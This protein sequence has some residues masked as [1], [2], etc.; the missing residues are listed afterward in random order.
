MTPIDCPVAFPADP[1]DRRSLWLFRRGEVPAHVYRLDVATGERRLWKT[2]VPPD[3]AGVYSV[4]EFQITPDGQSYFY[5]YTRLLSQLYLV[6]GL[7]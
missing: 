5:S 1:A 6:R 7:K 3:S 4:I 2:L